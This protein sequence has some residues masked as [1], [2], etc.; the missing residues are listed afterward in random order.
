M[1]VL[2]KYYSMKEIVRKKVYDL[3]MRVDPSASLD[4]FQ[5]NSSLAEVFGLIPGKEDDFIVSLK[6]VELIV[7]TEC[8]LGIQIKK[9]YKNIF[10][11]RLKDFVDYVFYL[12]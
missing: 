2:I 5:E 7:G 9:D 12:T 8:A 11:M 6:I 1:C 3:I 10:F 4:G